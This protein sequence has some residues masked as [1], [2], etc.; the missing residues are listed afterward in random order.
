MSLLINNKS[1]TGATAQAFRITS[2]S[3]KEH[4][5]PLGEV[6][7]VSAYDFDIELPP[8]AAAEIESLLK[9]HAVITNNGHPVVSG[10]VTTAWGVQLNSRRYYAVAMAE[11]AQLGLRVPPR[12]NIVRS[13]GPNPTNG[14]SIP[15]SALPAIPEAS[16]D[17]GA[18]I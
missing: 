13:F 10:S 17:D 1:K 8:E 2:R 16:V 7:G 9:K 18:S 12:P 3:F 15:T 5:G 4:L 6:L 14:V 11:A